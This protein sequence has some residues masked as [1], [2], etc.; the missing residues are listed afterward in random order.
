LLPQIKTRKPLNELP[1]ELPI[2]C[3]RKLRDQL[4]FIH[5]SK[6]RTEQIH[7]TKA[8]KQRENLSNDYLL[9][10]RNAVLTFPKHIR[11]TAGHGHPRLRWSAMALARSMTPL[12]SSPRQVKV[13]V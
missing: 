4:P 8:K 9:D 3:A 5:P 1:I 2:A 6:K 12:L 13:K 11:I 10:L 7:G